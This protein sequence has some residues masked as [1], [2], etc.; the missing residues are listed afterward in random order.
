MLRLVVP[1]ITKTAISIGM[2]TKLAK[3]YSVWLL[4]VG[5]SSVVTTLYPTFWYIVSSQLVPG[6]V[7][8]VIVIESVTTPDTNSSGA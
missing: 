2:G 7:A 8:T 5:V 1:S 4:D 6:L 3:L